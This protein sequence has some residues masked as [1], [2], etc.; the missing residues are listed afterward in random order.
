[1]KPCQNIFHVQDPAPEKIISRTLIEELIMGYHWFCLLI[2]NYLLKCHTLNS[3]QLWVP[4][5]EKWSNI[6]LV[7]SGQ[8]PNGDPLGPFSGHFHLALSEWSRRCLREGRWMG[9]NDLI[10]LSIQTTHTF[11]DPTK[12]WRFPN[13]QGSWNHILHDSVDPTWEASLHSATGRLY[14]GHVHSGRLITGHEWIA[15]DL[16]RDGFSTKRCRNGTHKKPYQNISGDIR[17]SVHVFVFVVFNQIDVSDFESLEWKDIKGTDMSAKKVKK[18]YRIKNMVVTLEYPVWLVKWGCDGFCWKDLSTIYLGI[19]SAKVKT[20]TDL[21]RRKLNVCK[22][23]VICQQKLDRSPWIT[24]R[25]PFPRTNRPQVQQ[26]HA[27]VSLI[28]SCGLAQ[29]KNIQG[30]KQEMSSVADRPTYT[31][32]QLKPWNPETKPPT[33]R[34]LDA[35]NWLT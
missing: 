34:A 27:W 2:H 21:K 11:C 32:Y 26:I 24:S 12:V 5:D 13:L 19:N 4:R 9:N 31:R 35:R 3:Q 29:F 10:D 30:F 22:R 17:K 7:C 6:I 1:M 8:V 25:H 20:W 18:N 16:W 15:G 23:Y 33:P 14:F 28:P